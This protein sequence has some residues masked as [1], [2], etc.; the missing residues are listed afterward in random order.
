MVVAVMGCGAVGLA[1]T[2]ELLRRGCSVRL[3]D[4]QPDVL[5]DELTQLTGL[6]HMHEKAG[7]LLAGDVEA[8][9]SRCLVAGT[10]ADAI[11]ERVVPMRSW[12]AK[13]ARCAAV[14]RM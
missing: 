13:D 4:T 14:I 11:D 8:L 1:I 12:M 9:M 7:R 3:Y 5:R 10:L 6:F 2:G